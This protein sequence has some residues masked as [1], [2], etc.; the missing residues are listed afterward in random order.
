MLTL[1]SGFGLSSSFIMNLT[2]SPVSIILPLPSICFAAERWATLFLYSLVDFLSFSYEK[3]FLLN[4]SFSNPSHRLLKK[5]S[6]LGNAFAIHILIV[7]IP[8]QT[9]YQVSLK[10]LD[11]IWYII[12][13][14]LNPPCLNFIIISYS[15]VSFQC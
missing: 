10:L 13:S 3:G 5:C 1:Q 2:L 7:I 14:H 4:I 15:K 8:H 6:C 12:S 11:E 9:K